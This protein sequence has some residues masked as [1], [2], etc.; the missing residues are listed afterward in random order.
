MLT[1]IS[2]AADISPFQHNRILNRDWASR[3]PGALWGPALVE[4]LGNDF[5]VVTGDVALSHVKTGFWLPSDVL[6]IQHMADP[7]S[8]EL[9]RLG[10]TPQVI[11]TF[12]SPLYAGS[13]FDNL[14]AY[15]NSFKH[16]VFFRGSF[17]KLSCAGRQVPVSFPSFSYGDTTADLVPW[18]SRELM[19]AIFSNKYV[20]LPNW[21]QGFGDFC[22]R[23]P[24]FL[25]H[26]LRGNRV[27]SNLPL[28]QIQLQDRR[29]ELVIHFLRREKLKLFGGGWERFDRI[30]PSK[31]KELLNLLSPGDRKIEDKID[32][33]KNFKFCLCLENCSYP[34]Y[35]TE[36]IID[37]LV[38]G[39]IPLYQGAPD[40]TD[41]IPK[42]CFIDISEE[43][44]LTK[45]ENRLDQI[46]EVEGMKM[47]QAGQDFLRSSQA[48][49][50]SYQGFAGKIAELLKD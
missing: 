26:Y 27:A 35:V 40:V 38:A 34:G 25:Y 49:P 1:K 42:D 37:C 45:L 18:Q 28:H 33:L 44:D 7:I 43:M 36:K 16:Q 3:F 46:S 50:F 5:E 15:A 2:F 20:I 48:Y 30:P 31:R 29:L 17:N 4:E 12:E 32:H 14:P 10:C 23:F 13:F 39:V 47:I 41:F 24:R 19:V 11:T 9:T 21:N 8:I 6:V 22:W